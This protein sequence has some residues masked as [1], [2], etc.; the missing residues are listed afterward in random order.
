MATLTATQSGNLSNSATWGGSTF[1]NNDRILIGNGYTVTIDINCTIGSAPASTTAQIACSGTGNFIINEDLTVTIRGVV[2][3]ENRPV[4]NAGVTINCEVP[5]VTTYYWTWGTGT[6]STKGLTISGTAAKPVTINRTGAGNGHWK[7]A[8]LTGYVHFSMSYCTIS[9]AGTSSDYT[10]KFDNFNSLVFDHVKFNSC[11]GLEI[12]DQ[13]IPAVGNLAWQYVVFDNLVGTYALYYDVVTSVGSYS[14][15]FSKCSLESVI[16]AEAA[17]TTFNTCCFS[18]IDYTGTPVSGALTDCLV[19]GT[20]IAPGPTFT[21]TYMI[22]GGSA[23][24]YIQ[25]G[26]TPSSFTF[27]GLIVDPTTTTTNAAVFTTKNVSSSLDFNISN[28]IVLPNSDDTAL[29][30]L[31]AVGAADNNH[32]DIKNCTLFCGSD[33]GLSVANASDTGNADNVSNYQDNMLWSAAALTNTRAINQVGAS[34]VNNYI[35][36]ADHNGRYNI[37]DAYGDVTAAAFKV[38]PGTG[39]ITSDPSFFDS[40]RDHA[41]WATAFLGATGTF[42]EKSAACIAYLKDVFDYTRSGFSSSS[43]NQIDLYSWVKDGFRVR[44]ASYATG[45]STGGLIGAANYL[46]E[47]AGAGYT[48]SSGSGALSVEIDLAGAGYT[49]SSGSGELDLEIDLAG[50]GYTESSGAGE[51]DLEIDLA[52]AGYTESSG[53]GE[54]DLAIDLAGAGYTAS[55]G[56]GELDLA[57]D[58]AGAGY[59]V[60]SG[61]GELDLEIDLAGAGYTASSG[62][63][64]LDLEIDLAGAGY[65]TSSGAGELDLEIYLAGAGYTVSSGAGELDLE[66]DLAGAGYTVSSGLGTL[67]PMMI[68]GDGYTVSSG[69]GDLEVSIPVYLAGAGYTVSSGLGALSP[70]LMSGAGYTVSSGFGDMLVIPPVPSKIGMRDFSK[71]RVI[72]TKTNSIRYEKK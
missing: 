47:I 48:A 53:A 58:L 41:A 54:L 22:A 24:K 6:S 43:I 51:L 60:S 4:I 18:L 72:T 68:S 66:I 27:N 21:R 19:A 44:T 25:F 50:A 33:G 36:A 20:I 3:L 23:Y 28:A 15:N 10:C 39:D 29:G 55:S 64:E 38:T 63:G 56:A 40:A 59:T 61:A 70:I 49:V 46:L 42:A 8:Y 35:S 57:I 52:G 9:N 16:F 11:A 7:F 17:S 26:W 45:S 67:S 13:S 14:R 71:T 32:W 12:T 2:S 69:L 30:C 1:V 37:D 62:A 5:G 65:T 31:A 34:I